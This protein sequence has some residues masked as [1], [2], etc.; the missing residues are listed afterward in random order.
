MR[1]ILLRP[2]SVI[3]QTNS[4]RTVY[5]PLRGAS[6]KQTVFNNYAVETGGNRLL[7]NSYSGIDFRA[8]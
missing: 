5:K 4:H 3:S 6:H 2:S 7:R 1:D 8:F